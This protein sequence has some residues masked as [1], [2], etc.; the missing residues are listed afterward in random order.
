MS[1]KIDTCGEILGNE[2]LAG[3]C[4]RLQVT[5]AAGFPLPRPGQFALLKLLR[6]HDPLLGRP[7]SIYDFDPANGV[8]TFLY[9]VVGRG[10]AALSLQKKGNEIGLFGPLGRPFQVPEGASRLV[11]VAGGIGVAALNLLARE[12]GRR[13]G[14]RI[15]CYLGARSASDIIGLEQLRSACDQVK[16]T[17][18]DGSVGEK[19]LVTEI[20]VRDLTELAEAGAHLYACGPRGMLARL[21]VMLQECDSPCQISLE[22][23]MACGLGACLG[24]V[25]EVKDLPDVPYRRVCC[26]GPVF[27]IREICW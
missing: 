14:C 24:C 19:G 10:T 8:A 4:F 22:E 11:L 27:D 20:L 25:V 1:E 9:Q 12:Y 23:R 6:G 3:N 13:R 5:V 26:D 15:D 17:T 2:R 21:A 16:I 18:E 7:L